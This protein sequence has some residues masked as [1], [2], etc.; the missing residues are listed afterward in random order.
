[1]SK[2]NHILETLSF[3]CIDSREQYKAGPVQTN[4]IFLGF[5]NYQQKT[6]SGNV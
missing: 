3:P 2:Y 4:Y 6:N 5:I 1:M